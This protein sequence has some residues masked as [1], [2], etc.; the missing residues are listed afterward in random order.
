[1]NYY[2]VEIKNY[3]YEKKYNILIAAINYKEALGKVISTY[4]RDDE[5]ENIKISNL[6]DMYEELPENVVK[7]LKEFGELE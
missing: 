3:N 4:I 6:C 2:L 1:M 5:V 7:A